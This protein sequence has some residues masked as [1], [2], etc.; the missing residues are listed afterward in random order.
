MLRSDLCDCSDAYID[1]EGD[2]NVEGAND[3]DKHNR[4]LILKNNAPFISC[5]SKI[6]NTECRRQC[7]RFRHCNAYVP[8]D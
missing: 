3:T 7:R 4:V 5:I 6:N 8:F 2:I 1:V